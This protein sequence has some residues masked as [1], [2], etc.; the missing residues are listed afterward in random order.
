VNTRYSLDSVLTLEEVAAKLKVSVRTVRS[1][2]YKRAIPFT[3]F[4]RRVYVDAGVVEE[5]LAR[6]ATPAL[7]AKVRQV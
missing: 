4:Q 1:W 6:N 3:R 7:P 2:V 5:L